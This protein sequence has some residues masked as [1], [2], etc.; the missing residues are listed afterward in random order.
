MIE[1]KSKNFIWI[2]AGIFLLALCM[3]V[4]PVSAD[5]TFR[6]VKQWNGDAGAGGPF[7]SPWGVAVDSANNVY[8]GDPGNDRVQIFSS[9][10]DY[11][12][13]IDTIDT[14]WGASSGVAV[15]SANNVYIVEGQ[16]IA[17]YNA[18]GIKQW[19]FFS[20]DLVGGT[21]IAV[22]SA[23]T[24]YVTSWS[25]SNIQKFSS[26]DGAFINTF[27]PSVSL[28]TP[29]GIAV[30]TDDNVY[31]AD[32]GNNRVVK[33]NLE[34]DE[35]LTI[36]T[37]APEGVA[38]DS[39]G[40]IFV[41]SMT[42]N[43]VKQFYP[44]GNLRTQ[45]GSYG[46]GGNGQFQG[47]S[48]IAVTGFSPNVYVA[49][50]GGNRIQKFD[51]PY[52]TA[53]VDHTTGPAGDT[54]TF[55]GVNTFGPSPAYYTNIVVTDNMPPIS[56]G[57][58]PTS[59]VKP[60]DFTVVTI[61]GNSATVVQAP[62]SGDF[63]Q[64]VWHTSSINGGPVQPGHEY[65]FYFVGEPSN[66]A[67]L[68]PNTYTKVG[69]GIN[70]VHAGYT[71]DKTSCLAPCTIAFSDI[72]LG[73]P[74]DVTEWSIDYG[75]GVS[76]GP[77]GPGTTQ[78]HTYSSPNTYH[79]V[80]SATNGVDSDSA[81]GAGIIIGSAHLPPAPT[82][83]SIAP[84][85]GALFG[86][87]TVTI[88]GTALTGTTD[89]TFG[90]TAATSIN[91]NSDTSITA[92]SPAKT[93]GIVDVLVTTPYGT[94][95]A[96]PGDQFT[97]N[98]VP[99]VTGILP[100]TGS[101]VDSPLAV[102]ITG[103]DFLPGA[104][105]MVF[106]GLYSIPESN[107]QWVDKNHIT[108]TLTITGNT[109]RT[110]DVMVG[111]PDGQG[112]HLTDGF[113]VIAPPSGRAEAID[114]GNTY[115]GQNPPTKDEE[116]L[117][118][119]DQPVDPGTGIT[120]ING[121]IITSPGDGSYWVEFINL[122]KNDNWG[123]PAKLIFH[124]TGKA[125]VVYNVDFPPSDENIVKFL[126]EGGKV[127]NYAGRLSIDIAPDPDFACTPNAD[128]NYAVLI[129]GGTDSTQNYAR[130]YND[131][132]F[133]YNTLIG[134]NYGYSPSHIKVVMSDGSDVT[135][136]DQATTSGTIDSNPRLDGT[137]AVTIKRATKVNVTTAI[138]TWSPAL[139][140]A[141]TLFIFTTG[142]GER[143]T[144]TAD[145]TNDVNLLLWGTEKISDTDLVNAIPSGPKVLMMMEQCYAG[146]FKDEFIP[147]QGSNI[148]VLATAARGD[149]VSHS[150]EYSYYFITAMAGKDSAGILVDADKTPVDGQV[151][152]REAHTY[153][154]N[155][156]PSRVAGTETPQFFEWTTNP[157]A[158]STNYASTCAA[159]KTIT[160]TI[161]SGTWTAGQSKL[162]QWATSGFTTTPTLKIELMNASGWQADI[163]ASVPGTGAAGTAGVT[164]TVPSTLPGGSQS[165]Y[166]VLIS[167]IGTQQGVSGQSS[168]FTTSGVSSQW[169]G[170]LKVT[171]SPTGAAI[172]LRDF[173]YNPVKINNVEQSGQS[174]DYNWTSIAPAKY[175]VKAVKSCYQDV[176]FAQKQV[177]P[178][179]TTQAPFTLVSLSN[180]NNPGP[181][182]SIAITSLPKEGFRVWLKGGTLGSAFVDMG[183]ET[184]VIQ[185][186]E[187]GTYSVKLEANGYIPQEKEVTVMS[188]GDQ[189][190]ADFVLNRLPNTKPVIN[191]IKVPT[192]PVSTPKTIT[193]TATVTDVGNSDPLTAVW[194]WDDPTLP[195]QTQTIN[196]DPNT[197]KVTFSI[198]HELKSPDVFKVNL[199]VTDYEGLSDY[200]EAPTFIIGYD[201][202]AGYVIGAGTII[203][204]KGAY[205]PQP[206]WTGTGY[207]GFV[208]K[209][210]KGISRPQGVTEF[211]Y[212]AGNM[213][214]FSDNYD[215][216][217][218]AGN[219]AWYK[220]SGRI[221]GK[222]DYGFLLTATDGALAPKGSDK[223]RI[224]IWNKTPFQRV[225]DTMM[226]LPDDADPTTPLQ[227]GFIVIQK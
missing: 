64:Y 113:S 50:N 204:P 210:K 61:T 77:F 211:Y 28:N 100:N 65:L 140:S 127:P 226:D 97:Y 63:W 7:N 214:F 44:D 45:W 90:G 49:E 93:A 215:V 71:N 115:L 68:Q 91:V 26:I 153:A 138:S 80:I 24:I 133:L 23:G 157:A 200:K 76:G 186:V 205:L 41:T 78:S 43:N 106:K 179:A 218:V 174:T 94:S 189:A 54:F 25:D 117:K 122:A 33:I 172:I 48:G 178:N 96:V 209:Y 196:T 3:A 206:T 150:N 175:W 17:K 168:T 31:V 1:I 73:I 201:P 149:Q 40:T 53:S 82:V 42:L 184:P 126:H 185:D 89:V 52:L 11:L 75:D 74:V 34:G 223:F 169:P 216:L 55:S 202:N 60:D 183:Y 124:T 141:D 137:N 134:P 224:R 67:D 199:T 116:E 135:T 16:V 136:A 102:T 87:T 13:M 222:G 14:A 167:S 18:A 159:T 219:K 195:V 59:G 158:G 191:E 81:I 38:V 92:T 10:G 2:L 160:V 118:V 57:N 20:T 217:V 194:K 21:G 120:L 9:D 15:D 176:S 101:S 164:W 192:D 143:V 146:G 154:N 121:Q 70:G 225:Y 193:V 8:V 86:G 110:Y 198:T 123:H 142:H 12:R 99:T 36:P 171:S 173:R 83:T 132:K 170:A 35:V 47:P 104:A 139:T 203:S 46:T 197:G 181:I 111:N 161:P 156:D 69:I 37:D 85:N 112:G 207:F 4:V 114:N 190:R 148:R 107:V 119:S 5:T 103:N 221:N 6:F 105:V 66:I 30:D 182:G 95:T 39:L 51:E 162:I 145:N 227:W 180:C 147:A 72:S 109:P 32:S 166:Y 152:M 212:D 155:L 213:N 128:H 98:P 56:Y 84:D 27:A 22:D 19:S 177:N 151:S 79:P 129:S 58:L 29:H 165:G 188:G 131:I 62:V 163:S 220:G 125:D 208:S 144:N 130:Y 108:C 187:A 88:T